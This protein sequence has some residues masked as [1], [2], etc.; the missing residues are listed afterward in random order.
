MGRGLNIILGL[1]L[2]VI[3]ANVLFG[4]VGAD[5]EY[6]AVASSV[7]VILIGLFVIW[8]SSKLIGLL[9][10]LLG[11]V[12]LA[13]KWIVDLFSYTAYVPWVVAVLGGIL[14]IK[15]SKAGIV[16]IR[17]HHIPQIAWATDKKELAS[18]LIKTGYVKSGKDPFVNHS[19]GFLKR[20]RKNPK[21]KIKIIAGREDVI[22]KGCPKKGI[23]CMN[24]PGASS[25]SP[26]QKERQESV[27]LKGVD[28]YK[29]VDNSALT[30]TGLKIGGVYTVEEVLSSFGQ[31]GIRNDRKRVLDY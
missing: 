16:E 10:I 6:L 19:F 24:L 26:A 25:L 22:C 8:K 3:S 27:F 1:V 18:M 14:I 31:E 5:F 2:I 20:L 12:Q 13:E 17:A 28:T 15:K 30:G 11:I 23:T 9:V 21:T 29:R 7:V 4:F